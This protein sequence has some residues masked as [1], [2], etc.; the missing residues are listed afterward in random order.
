M[1]GMGEAEAQR[2]ARVALAARSLAHLVL[3]LGGSA[4]AQEALHLVDAPSLC[5][6]PQLHVQRS[7]R[8]WRGRRGKAGPTLALVVRAAA[9]LGGSLHSIQNCVK[10]G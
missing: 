8:C 7:G 10:K 1:D 6:I 2:R 4:F 3:V 5:T 9:S